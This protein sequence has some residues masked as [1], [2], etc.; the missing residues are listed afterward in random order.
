M[1]VWDEIKAGAGIPT[2]TVDEVK[3]AVNKAVA[4]AAKERSEVSAQAGGIRP[5]GQSLESSVAS[6]D[7][8][9]KQQPQVREHEM[10]DP[11]PD[12]GVAMEQP[13]SD[14]YDVVF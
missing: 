10:Q 7:V 13:Q 3:A 2:R 8:A 14:G 1:A 4:D 6:M 11:A 9:A 12:F 5:E